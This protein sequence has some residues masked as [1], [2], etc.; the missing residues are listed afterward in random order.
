[1]Q[2][3]E[4]TKQLI[5]SSPN[6]PLVILEVESGASAKVSLAGPLRHPVPV[7]C[8]SSPPHSPPGAECEPCGSEPRNCLRAPLL[9]LSWTEPWLESCG[10]WRWMASLSP[11]WARPCAE[12]PSRLQDQCL[13]LEAG[14]GVGGTLRTES[15]KPTAL[16]E[17]MAPFP[18]AM[19]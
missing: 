12:P 6:Q 5:D 16:E 17:S 11:G 14:A 2:V 13:L 9:G 10:S 1:M 18:R 7:C 4:K 8:P 15:C 19:A 3:L